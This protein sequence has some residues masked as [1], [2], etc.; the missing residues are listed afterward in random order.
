MDLH[1][2]FVSFLKKRYPNCIFTATLGDYQDTSKKRLASHKKGYLRGSPHLII[3]NLYK[4]YTGFAIEFKTPKVISA[5]SY[6]QYKMLRQY[7]NSSVQFKFI[8]QNFGQFTTCYLHTKRQKK[9]VK[10]QIH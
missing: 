4:H 6:D 5:L 2:K 10:E 3:N 1:I 9:S 8:S 7:E